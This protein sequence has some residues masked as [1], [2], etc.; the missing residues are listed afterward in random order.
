MEISKGETVRDMFSVFKDTF[1]AQG[2]VNSSGDTYHI[3]S[4]AILFHHHFKMMLKVKLFW[5][6]KGKSASTESDLNT[7]T[8]VDRQISFIKLFN[9]IEVEKQRQNSNSR[10][11]SRQARLRVE[12]QSQGTWFEQ[13]YT[14]YLISAHYFYMGKDKTNKI[15]SDGLINLTLADSV[16]LKID[17]EIKAVVELI[18]AELNKYPPK[19][20]VI[21]HERNSQKANNGQNLELWPKL[22]TYLQKKNY[23]VWTILATGKN[24]TIKDDTTTK[25]FPYMVD[26]IDYG[27]PYH[28]L[29]LNAI[30][31]IEG[32]VGVIG[33]T[34]GTLDLAAFLGLPVYNL[35]ATKT[36]LN[37]Q[38]LRILIQKTF[39][40]VQLVDPS[41]LGNALR[42]KQMDDNICQEQLPQL[43]DWLSNT[44]TISTHRTTYESFLPQL[45]NF[46]FAQ[47]LCAQRGIKLNSTRLDSTSDLLQKL[48]LGQ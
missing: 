35:H 33:N 31:Q 7:F 23:I 47:L 48:F 19:K 32:F 14:T 13:K 43:L 11:K 15:L 12:M 26:G 8:Q 22:K 42:E 1:I 2:P 5:D 30:K 18:Q 4:A 38:T 28:L 39:L 46:G 9:C 44:D 6:G 37:Y 34:S 21:L 27:K 20:L 45:K 36:K 24:V 40:F 41:L 16:R 25:P 10:E 29:L 3:L 17:N